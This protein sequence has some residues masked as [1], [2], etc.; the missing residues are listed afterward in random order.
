MKTCIIL[1]IIAA[2]ISVLMSAVPPLKPTAS[3]PLKSTP[4][5]P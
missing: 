2:G 4:T 1:L 5:P 3:A